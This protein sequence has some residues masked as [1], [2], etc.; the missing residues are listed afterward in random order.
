MISTWILAEQS[1]TIIE[2]KGRNS[3]TLQGAAK[4]EQS[5][6]AHLMIEYWPPK[7]TKTIVP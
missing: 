1:S 7:T 6:S 4:W 2:D 5:L 3:N